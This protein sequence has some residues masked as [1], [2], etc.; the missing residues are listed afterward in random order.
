[1]SGISLLGIQDFPGQG[2]ALVGMLN[3]H[4]R[5]KPYAFAAPERFRKFYTGILPVAL[6]PKY[7]YE[8]GEMFQAELKMANYGKDILKGK[9]FWRLME[10]QNIRQEG[11]ND[12]SCC[13]PGT[14]T[15]TGSAS[16]KLPE[17]DRAV[18]YTLQLCY[19]D[20]KRAIFNNEYRIWSYPHL[21][22][23]RLEEDGSA[24]HENVFITQSVG[25]A[26]QH[27]RNGECVFLSPK[28]L[29][30]QFSGSAA[31]MFS[32]D[33]WSVGTFP[34]QEGY[35]GCLI[36][37]KHPIFKNFPTLPW[38]QWQWWSIT[39]GARSMKI[40]EHLNAIIS[41]I[42]C[43]ARLRRL[44]FLFECRVGSGRLTVSSMGLLEKQEYPETRALL[45]AILA[46]MNTEGFAPETSLTE[47][48][49]TSIL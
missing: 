13:I 42:D 16:L 12:G 32:T 46:Y 4:L 47:D 7:T 21:N 2:T 14:L 36:D 34:Q 49:L 3:S 41:V 43:Y 26:L 31:G 39:T 30:D 18:C 28:A 19:K 27:L 5:T 20:K 38:P 35:M 44:A 24:C 40:P 1:M 45:Q 9:M 17:T 29:A 33:F 8:N 37:E 25:Q 10:A 15:M 23:V 6:F 11:K 22:T 48:E